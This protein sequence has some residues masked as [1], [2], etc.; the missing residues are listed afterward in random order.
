MTQ[1]TNRVDE[2]LQQE[3]G[4]I[5]ERD[6]SDP[7]IGF[8]TVTGVE[9]TPDLRHAQVWVSVIAQEAEREESLRALRHAAPFIRRELGSRLRIKRIPDLHIRLD[10]SAERG[11]RVL[12]MIEELE[13]GHEPDATPP[14]ESL[15]TPVA[16]IR[17]EGDAPEEPPESKAAG[18]RRGRARRPG[19]PATRSRS[20]RGSGR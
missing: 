3:I 6:V 17:R 11:T 19:D 15:P 4:A 10:D 12:R 13:A 20:R 9:T 18:A 7:R 2:L 1:R 5:L 14:G 8:V 16:R